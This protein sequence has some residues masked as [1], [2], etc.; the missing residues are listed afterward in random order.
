MGSG[1]DT[2]TVHERRL[3][4]TPVDGGLIGDHM[5]QYPPLGDGLV[6]LVG[7]PCRQGIRVGNLGGTIL[8]V[9]VAFERGTGE[10]REQ[11]IAAAGIAGSGVVRAGQGGQREDRVVG[12]GRVVGGHRR[13]QGGHPIGL[14]H[15][16]H[17]AGLFGLLATAP[18]R[19]RIVAENHPVDHV[20]QPLFGACQVVCKSVRCS[21]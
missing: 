4:V 15:H 19:I 6:L 7:H 20:D 9:A 2:V 16:P 8:A 11:G 12:D 17:T 1:D 21:I 3:V 14:G 13:P 5:H 18:H 10:Q